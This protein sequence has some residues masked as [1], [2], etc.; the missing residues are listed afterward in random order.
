MP[1]ASA[2]AVIMRA[3]H[4]LRTSSQLARLVLAWFML[5]W[6]V[7]VAAPV[8]H[9]QAMEL[10]CSDAGRMKL[11]AI[12]DGADAAPAGHHTLD[13]AACLA[14][15]PP[16]P[17]VQLPL[18]ATPPR[19]PVFVLIAPPPPSTPTGAALPPRGPPSHA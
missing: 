13:C 15:L 1:T 5:A 10:V 8:L 2:D 16:P 19:D 14:V 9:P 7:A 12:G 18:G 6:G 11:V 4:A 3:M 17:A